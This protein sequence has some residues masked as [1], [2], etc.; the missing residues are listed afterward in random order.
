MR[1][2]PEGLPASVRGG[3]GESEEWK[4]KGVALR[5]FFYIAGTHIFAG[6]IYLLFYV[7]QHAQK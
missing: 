6:F 7:G 5:A 3:G 1:D 4:A 2:E